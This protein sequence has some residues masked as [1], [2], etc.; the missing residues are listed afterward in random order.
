MDAGPAGP[1]CRRGTNVSS[2]K[3]GGAPIDM[4]DAAPWHV[5]WSASS[6]LGSVA[7]LGS[8]TTLEPTRPYPP[9]SWP[10]SQ[11]SGRSVTCA[12]HWC[13]W[14]CALTQATAVKPPY[15]AGPSYGQERPWPQ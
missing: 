14:Y 12:C 6:A 8:T 7:V 10:W 11:G 3:G 4:Q 13:V 2:R 9:S 15:N 1:S 5:T